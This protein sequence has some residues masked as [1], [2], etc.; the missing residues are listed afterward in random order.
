MNAHTLV[1]NEA[2]DD[3]N[4]TPGALG[5]LV[6]LLRQSDTTGL[7]IRKIQKAMSGIGE[8]GLT[9][10]IHQLEELGYLR[11]VQDHVDGRFQPGRYVVTD[12]PEI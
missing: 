1:S 5:L 2:I 6:W 11:R 9:R 4:L 3:K 10:C 8:V 12:R 7:T